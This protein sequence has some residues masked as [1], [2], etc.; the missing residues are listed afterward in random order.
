M[1]RML[2]RA[3][4]ATLVCGMV[5]VMTSC[6]SGKT[7][8]ETSA[9]DDKSLAVKC[10]N[11]T[12]VGRKAENVIAYNYGKAPVQAPGDIAAEYGMGEDCLYLN[13]WRADEAANADT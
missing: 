11:G 9:S 3:L 2:N 8:K 5:A 4:A 10:I 1:R 13:I 6:K 7:V 12:F